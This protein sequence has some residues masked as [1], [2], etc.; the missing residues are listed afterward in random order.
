MKQNYLH[1]FASSSNLSPDFQF[2]V[3]S[4]ELALVIQRIAQTELAHTGVEGHVDPRH[5]VVFQKRYPEDLTNRV[6][7][8]PVARDETCG[9]EYPFQMTFH[10]KLSLLFSRRFRRKNTT[11]TVASFCFSSIQRDW[12]TFCAL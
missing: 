11:L 3:R 6:L 4:P 9:G 1:N 12:S 5:E 2:L 10:D 8:T 7:A